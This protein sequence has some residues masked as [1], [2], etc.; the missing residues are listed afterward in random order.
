MRRVIVL[1]GSLAVSMALTAPGASADAPL[2]DRLLD[3]GSFTFGAGEMCDF[4]Y[5]YSFDTTVHVIAWGAPEQP[6]KLIAHLGIEATHTNLDTGV[7]LTERSSYH[8]LL[9]VGG[10]GFRSVGS[11]QHLWTAAGKNL[12]LAAGQVWF[13]PDPVSPIRST[14]HAQPGLPDGNA[15]PICTA[16]GGAPA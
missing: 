10:A 16:L 3:S 13:A 7:S 12:L 15:E 2:Q 14:P 8:Q 6:R 9:N 1:L 5:R 11:L 4:A